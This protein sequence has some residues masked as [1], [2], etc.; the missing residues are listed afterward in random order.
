MLL[1]ITS[2]EGEVGTMLEVSF[3]NEKERLNVLTQE[4]QEDIQKYYKY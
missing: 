2:F 4:V 1:R 3:L